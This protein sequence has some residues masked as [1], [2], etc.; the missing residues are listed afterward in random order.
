MTPVVESRRK[1]VLLVEDDELFGQAMNDYLSDR[2]SVHVADSEE[3]AL[4][5]LSKEGAQVVLLDITLKGQDGISVLKTIRARWPDLPVIMLSAIERIPTVV[6]CIKLGAVDYLAKPPIV[7]ELLVSLQRAI[8]AAE[9]RKE[10]EQRRELQLVENRE[11]KM[12]GQSPAIDKVRKQIEVVGKSDSPVLITGETGTGKELAAREIHACSSRAREPFVA[13]NCGAIPKDLFETEFFGF[14]KGAFTGAQTSEIGKLQLANRGTLLLDEISE[15]PLDAQTKLLRIIEEH[16]FY[17]V[18][19]SQLSYVDIRVVACTNRRLEEMVKEKLFREDLYFRLNVY[20]IELPPLRER[21]GDLFLLAEHFMQH[22]NRK[23]NKNFTKISDEMREAMMHR[24]WKGNIRELR[25]VMERIIL[26]E[27][28]EV[29]EMD[30]LFGTFAVAAGPSGEVNISMPEY[31]LDIQEVEKNLILQALR[32]ANG[33]K[34]K[35]AKLL[36][37]SPATLY[38]RLDKYHIV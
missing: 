17:P 25:N 26:S 9:I 6:E 10:L 15:M 5:H 18:G 19:S 38:Y 37:L 2:Y 1:D 24:A 11:Y 33:N 22:F 28:G 7:E 35:A 29:I 31:G 20:T 13:I 12:I 4:S 23:F 30:H 14:K 36:N 3:T 16:E 32:I 8:E 21:A 34:T 27:N